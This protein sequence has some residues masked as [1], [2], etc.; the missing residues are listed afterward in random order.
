[1]P[2]TTAPEEELLALAEAMRDAGG[3]VLQMIPSGT[4]GGVEG[5]EGENIMAGIA[6]LR[7]KHSLTTEIAMMRRIH[8]A[9]GQPITFTFADN[10]GLGD[11]E[12]QRARGAIDEI[13]AAGEQIRPQFSPRSVGMLL[14]LDTYHAFTMRPS[15][16]ALADL[17][18]PGI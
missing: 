16:L 9:T 14:S 5:E 6:S 12:Y 2:G 15:Y 1:M 13:R 18:S 10:P 11:S 17:F 4:S 7:D 8:R 3:G